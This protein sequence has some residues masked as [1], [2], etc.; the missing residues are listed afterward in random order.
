MAYGSLEV[1]TPS[2]SSMERLPPGTPV[3]RKDITIST[4]SVLE[5][6]YYL[7]HAIHVPEEHLQQG[8]VTITLDHEGNIFDWNEM[9][10]DLLQIFSSKHKPECAAVAVYYNGYWFYID[11]RDLE[12]QSTFTLLAE[13]FS[14]EIQGGGGAQLPVLTLGVGS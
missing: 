12:S 13:L 1:A 11:D 3:G 8:L 14:I 7:S 10:G 4:R 6:M 2:A 5:T 9:T